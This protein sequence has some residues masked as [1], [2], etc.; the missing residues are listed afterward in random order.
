MKELVFKYLIKN[1]GIDGVVFNN[2][3]Q[4]YHL[5]NIGGL[6]YQIKHIFSLSDWVSK[7]YVELWVKKELQLRR[8]VKQ[9]FRVINE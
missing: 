7:Y 6:I 8:R 3:K 9:G 4:L 5:D 1:Y 2:S